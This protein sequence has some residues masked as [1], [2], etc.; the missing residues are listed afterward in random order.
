MTAGSPLNET[1]AIEQEIVERV[2]AAKLRLR[3][4]KAVL[5]LV[6][7]LKVTLTN[8]VPEGQTIIFTVTAPIRLPAQTAAA[9]ENLVRKELLEGEL[10]RIIHGNQVRVRRVAGVQTHASRVVGFVHNPESDAGLILALTEARL[11]QRD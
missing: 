4:D 3:F 11:L 8:E 6:G 1:A 2:A 5:R 9:M 7:R 10:R